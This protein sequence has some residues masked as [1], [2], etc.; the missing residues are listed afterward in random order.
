MSSDARA[1]ARV[2]RTD[3][4]ELAPRDLRKVEKRTYTRV[5]GDVALAGAQDIEDHGQ[6]LRDTARNMP[7]LPAALST[8]IAFS[9]PP[10][11]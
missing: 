2:R 8:D 9:I 6:S 4:G 7:S 11:D 3:S 1:D 10:P 5:S